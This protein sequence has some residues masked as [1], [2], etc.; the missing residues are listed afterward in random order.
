VV[1]P[2]ADRQAPTVR[3]L[4]LSR[5]RFHTTPSGRRYGTTLRFTLSEPARLVLTVQR[6]SGRRL[7]RVRGTVVARRAAGRVS[8]RFTGRV[9]SRRLSPGRHVLTLVATDAAGN[10][11]TAVRRTFSVL[12]RRSAR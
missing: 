12:H 9:G 5:T 10:R 7:V 6:R 2:G 8:V 11:S 4:R 3:A 1:A